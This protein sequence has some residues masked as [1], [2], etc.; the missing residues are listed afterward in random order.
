MLICQINSGM[1]VAR[2]G[3]YGGVITIVMLNMRD[4]DF[5]VSESRT[6]IDR[7]FMRDDFTN[8]AVHHSKM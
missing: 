2:V 6:R 4:K 8:E 3:L 7:M 5:P 1:E